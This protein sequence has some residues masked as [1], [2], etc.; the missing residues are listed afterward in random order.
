[1]TDIQESSSSKMIL[2][3]MILP[4]FFTAE[5]LGRTIVSTKSLVIRAKC[6]NLKFPISFIVFSKHSSHCP[7]Q[8]LHVP[9]SQSIRSS[10]SVTTPIPTSFPSENPSHPPLIRNPLI[11]SLLKTAF[12]ILAGANSFASLQPLNQYTV[13][14]RNNTT[15]DAAQPRHSSC[16]EPF[17]GSGTFCLFA[18]DSL[19]SWSV[20]LRLYS[21]A[22]LATGSL[23]F[24]I[25]GGSS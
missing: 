25:S 12:F 10:I 16:S 9:K 6:P 13:R 11:L 23:A 5:F 17:G 7:R 14:P 19:S 20:C 15:H 18:G 3:Q 1:M 22:H 21:T 2:L 24:G 8:S 4:P